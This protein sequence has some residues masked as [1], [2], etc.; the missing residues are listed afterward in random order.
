MFPFDL[1]NQ[2]KLNE[3]L[4]QDPSA[5]AEEEERQKKE[6]QKTALL[7]NHAISEM[8]KSGL[9]PGNIHILL[10]VLTSLAVVIIFVKEYFMVNGYWEKQVFYAICIYAGHY[11]M[12]QVMVLMACKLILSSIL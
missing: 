8:M 10:G 7:N 1:G 5:R 12:I 11:L 6:R 2:A 4:M 3:V 9:Y